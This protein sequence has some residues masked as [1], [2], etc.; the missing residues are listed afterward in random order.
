[1]G[2]PRLRDHDACMRRARLSLD[3]LSVGDAFGSRF[4]FRTEVSRS[5][6]PPPWYYTD[7]TVMALAIVEHLD[8]HGQIDRGMLA[9]AFATRFAADPYRGYGLSVRR[10]LERIA[11]G[12][13]WEFA[14]GEVFGGAGSMG[15]GGAM[16]VAPLGA[17]FADDLDEVVEQARASA[18]VTHAHAE[19]QAGAI[20]TAVAAAWACQVHAHSRPRTG[21]DLLATVL[22][23][24]PGG[25][26]RTGLERAVALGFEC[27][28]EEAVAALGNGSRITAPDTVPFAL[29]SAAKH[30]DDYTEALWFTVSAGGDNDTNCAIVGG[31]VALANGREGIPDDWLAAREQLS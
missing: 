20:A 21:F 11:E 6:P 7:D 14:A 12:A 28:I 9:C 30:I 22:A 26:T 23:H 8:R 24:T 29:W 25:E 3:G 27:S 17:Y 15:N 4:N 19:G 18:E 16:R 13:P 1:M 2:T 31:I 10:V 5:L